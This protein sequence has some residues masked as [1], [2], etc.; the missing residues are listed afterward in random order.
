MKVK[1]FESNFERTEYTEQLCALHMRRRRRRTSVV[2]RRVY[3]R[4]L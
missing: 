3:V 2:L 1:F 4:V